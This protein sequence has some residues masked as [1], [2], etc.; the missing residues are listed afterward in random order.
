[1]KASI[2]IA[3]LNIK[4]NGHANV[5]HKNN[6]WYEVWQIMREG[7]V[8][9]LV[10]GEAHMTDG[11]KADIEALFSRV[12]RL[13]FTSDLINDR[14]RAGVAFILNKQLVET[15][16]ITTTEIIPGRA[17]LME[18]KN[19][20]GTPLSILGVY[21][22]NPPS[23]N[24]TFWTAIKE[25]F[26]RHPRVRK[27]DVMGGDMNVVEDG[28]DRLPTS[29]DPSSPVEA[30]DDLKEFFGMIDGWRETYPTT[31][32]YTFSQTPSQ[33]GSQSRIDRINI[34]RSLFEN[35]FD[36]NIQTVG[37]ETD[38]RMVSVRLTTANAPTV[39][40]GRWV[41]PAHIIRDKILT[42]F[43]HSEGLQLEGELEA[44]KQ[45]PEKRTTHYNAQTLWAKFKVG[46]GD[47]ARERAKIVIP[48]IV[49]QIA[50][51]ETKLDNILADKDTPQELKKLSSAV[52]VEKLVRLQKQRYRSSRLSAQIRNRLEGEVIGRYWSLVN[53]PGKPRE[54]VHRIRKNDNNP[55]TPPQ[56]ETNSKRMADIA[57]DYH[58][59]IQSDRSNAPPD[60]REEKMG[61]VLGR[62]P[63]KC[64]PEQADILRARLTLEDVILA[65]KMSSNFRAPGLDGITY[66]IWK[67]LHAR[68]E[69]AKSLNKQAFHIL[70]AMHTVYNDIETYGMIPGTGFSKSWMCPLYKKNDKSDIANYRPISL[71]NTDYKIMT[72]AL[73]IKL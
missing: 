21:A 58:D 51:Q 34:K 32:A 60:V 28:L 49:K 40:H 70:S 13:E 19:V 61:T 71:L 27:P 54:I 59:R 23:E 15:E 2:M 12:I 1:M 44:L 18:M 17:M 56:Y 22:P 57:R 46:I 24:A 35:S 52:I 26:V 47:K 14:G 11:K 9:V 62:T 66:E 36:W 73:T 43:I 3:A 39:G 31:C 6:K 63:K 20:D 45:A 38:H 7:R 55:E 41:W 50:E 53:K 69:T 72:K 30:L 42:E 29:N 37:I 64:T 67:I 4:G 10:V 33:G 68:Y 65:L 5:R 48:I 25:W 16:N 8:G